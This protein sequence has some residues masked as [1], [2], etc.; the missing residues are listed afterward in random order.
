MSDNTK[1]EN[2]TKE[3]N[4]TN[5]NNESHKLFSEDVLERQKKQR[6]L[7]VVW[8]ILSFI[9]HLIGFILLVIFTPLRELVI[10]EKP[11][12]PPSQLSQMSKE[13]IEEMSEDVE[14]HR[15]NEIAKYLEELQTVLH[16]MEYMKNELLKDYDEAAEQMAEE[17]KPE[18][19][20]LFEAVIEQQEISLEHQENSED[21]IEEIVDEQEDV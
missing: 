9:L 4:T 13:E 20:E 5:V 16:N 6:R 3:L 10:P 8:P 18:I 7:A 14:E 11:E 2:D 19:Q 15:Q 1:K 12:N 21:F 17:V